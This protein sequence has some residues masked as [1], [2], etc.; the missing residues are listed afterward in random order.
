VQHVVE[1]DA[2]AAID[3][4]AHRGRDCIEQPAENGAEPGGH[5][6]RRAGCGR[7]DHLDAQCREGVELALPAGISAA[8]VAG[9]RH[10]NEIVEARDEIGVGACLL[11][12]AAKRRLARAGRA[13]HQDELWPAQDLRHQMAPI[14]AA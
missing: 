6:W 2:V 8:I 7:I 12:R 1:D 5:A 4:G 13:V 11:Q 3:Q 10:E 14:A 9:C